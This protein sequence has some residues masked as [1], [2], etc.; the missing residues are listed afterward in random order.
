MGNILF[1]IFGSVFILLGILGL[2]SGALNLYSGQSQ[3]YDIGF[4]MGNLVVTSLF[5]LVGV[6][7]F[8]KASNKKDNKIE[9]AC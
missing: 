2:V 3:A 5:F 1:K 7:L 9:E 8:K 6:K 4:L